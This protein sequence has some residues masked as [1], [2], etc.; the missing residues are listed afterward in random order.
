M[1]KKPF[2]GEIIFRHGVKT[3]THRLQV[4]T[5]MPFQKT[6]KDLQLFLSILNYISKFPVATPKVC[7]P[8]HQLT[9]IKTDWM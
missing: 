3:D 2:F 7:K 8:L 6:K 9:S 1:H 4:Q 5:E